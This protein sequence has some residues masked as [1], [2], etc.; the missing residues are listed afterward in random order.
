MKGRRR[1]KVQRRRKEAF[2]AVET[3]WLRHCL[4]RSGGNSICGGIA[5]QMP[6][7]YS[8]PQCFTLN[9]EA[10]PLAGSS[11]TPEFFGH[12]LQTSKTRATVEE[13]TAGS[14][15]RPPCG[16]SSGWWVILPRRLGTVHE[17][18][19]TQAAGRNS[20]PECLRHRGRC[21]PGSLAL[22]SLPTSC[23]PHAPA[24]SSVDPT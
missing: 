17:L 8:I 23:G 9:C 24:G 21:S 1:R 12:R 18:A 7:G 13:S 20:G 4:S 6:W 5:T 11:E 14:G 16:A 15:P 2:E 3:P 19:G 22:G 10:L